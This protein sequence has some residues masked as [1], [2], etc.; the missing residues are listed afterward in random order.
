MA[1]ATLTAKQQQVYALLQKDKDPKTIAAEMGVSKAAIYSHIRAIKESGHPIPAKYANV[2]VGG[3]GAS[4]RARAAATKSG[5]KRRAASRKRATA[6]APTAVV[7][8]APQKGIGAVL[9]EKVIEVGAV[10]SG[11]EAVVKQQRE[12]IEV[13]RGQIAAEVE[14]LT[15][16]IDTLKAEDADL[17]S[18]L[19]RLENTRL[20]VLGEDAAAQAQAAT[21]KPTGNGSGQAEK[22]A[23]AT[24]T[25]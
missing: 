22:I 5:T 17:D 8:P 7:P 13:R 12:A 3:R 19:V 11:L 16:R 14:G 21:G 6:K 4:T 18:A 15:G 10:F 25:V 23:T 20:A 2:G 9:A 1:P 24:A